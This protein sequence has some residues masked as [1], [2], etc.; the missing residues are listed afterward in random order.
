M[1]DQPQNEGRKINYRNV[2]GGYAIFIGI[3]VFIDA[4]LIN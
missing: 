3:L 1:D 4:F 2:I